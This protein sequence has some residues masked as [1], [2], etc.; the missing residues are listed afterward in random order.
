MKLGISGHLTRAFI[1]SPLTP[2]FLIASLVV[3]L[4]ALVM[5]PR[6]EEPQISVP[7][8]DVFVQADGLK[9]P[10][11]IEL[12][13]KPLEEILK[14]IDGVEHTYLEEVGSMNIFFVIDGELITPALNGSILPGITRDSVIELA[15][16][17][18]W[19][20]SERQI[21]IDELIAAIQNGKLNEI[22][23]SGTAAVISPVGEIKY[24]N[25][26]YTVGDGQ[27]GPI[28]KKL[29]TAITDIQYGRAD[30]PMGWI[31]PV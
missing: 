24:N 8:V 6:E 13:T 29:Y 4:F 12:V 2:L 28:A 17:W 20:I 14:G 27:V 23:G 10:D 9:T 26:I 7:M 21:S 11:V 31:E 30:D 25:Q 15:K 1:N 16:F 5:V 3:G 18:D 19:K 22:F